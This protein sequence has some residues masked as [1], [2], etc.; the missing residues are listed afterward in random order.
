[1]NFTFFKF[2]KNHFFGAGSEINASF[3]TFLAIFT[4][5]VLE[6]V[7]FGCYDLELESLR[8]STLPN[9]FIF[10]WILPI[11]IVSVEVGQE[12]F[13]LLWQCKVLTEA[14]PIG[15]I[16]ESLSG[17]IWIWISEV[18]IKL[19]HSTFECCNFSVSLLVNLFNSGFELVQLSNHAFEFKYLQSLSL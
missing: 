5:V 8:S 6:L 15:H 1:M 11:W 4:V 16:D 2:F 9:N 19:N 17:G 7:L 13:H 14:V 12:S 3:Y 18:L 10:V